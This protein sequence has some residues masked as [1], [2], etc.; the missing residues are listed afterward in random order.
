MLLEA[1]LVGLREVLLEAAARGSVF[2]YSHVA[3]LKWTKQNGIT[4]QRGT[5]IVLSDTM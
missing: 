4:E 1:A 2:R 3:M 5:H